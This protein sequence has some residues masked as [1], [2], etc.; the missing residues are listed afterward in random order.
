MDIN[1]N[2]NYKVKVKF[3]DAGLE[4]WAKYY[5][6]LYDGFPN[7]SSYV[8]NK[9]KLLSKRMEDGYWEIPLYDLMNI[10][11]DLMC[12]G[13]INLPFETDIIIPVTLSRKNKI[14]IIEN[15]FENDEL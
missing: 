6:D 14:D 13:N 3:T 1:F 15:E 4:H 5:L 9:E 8:L 12:I 11:G 2:I 7:L 10:F